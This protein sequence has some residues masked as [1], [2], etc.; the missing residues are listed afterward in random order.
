ML[1]RPAAD[2]DSAK[3]RSAA[4]PSIGHPSSRSCDPRTH[5]SSPASF[6]MEVAACSSLQAVS[7]WALVRALSK[8]YNRANF[9]RMLR[10]RTN[11]RAA[12][13]LGSV[14]LMVKVPQTGAGVS[15]TISQY[16]VGGYATMVCSRLVP[17]RERPAL[18]GPPVDA[19]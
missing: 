9:N 15:V 18:P 13:C 2:R 6:L 7:N 19:R 11:A 4:A 1:A 5:S 8:P 16:P 17:N 12:E 14:E 3:L 10:L